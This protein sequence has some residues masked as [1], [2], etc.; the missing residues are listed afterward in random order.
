MRKCIRCKKEKEETEFNTRHFERGYLQSV[1]KDCQREQAKERY[2]NNT[3]NV[4]GINRSARLKA[5][6]EGKRLLYEYISQ[7]V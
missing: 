6:E 3:D 1:C 2:M 7:K 4:K 5:R